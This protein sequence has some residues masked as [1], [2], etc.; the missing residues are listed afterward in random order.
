MT[1]PSFIHRNIDLTMIY[2]PK[3]LYENSRIEL[4][5]AVP[6]VKTKLR[7]TEN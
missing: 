6:E 4:K 2:G 1:Q 7:K 3:Y 5:V